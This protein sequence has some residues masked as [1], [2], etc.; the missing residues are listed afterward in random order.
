M[1]SGETKPHQNVFGIQI[2]SY[3]ASHF[4]CPRDTPICT[5]FPWGG[6]EVVL[7]FI[8]VFFEGVWHTT[9]SEG[10]LRTGPTLSLMDLKCAKALHTSQIFINAWTKNTTVTKPIFFSNSKSMSDHV[11]PRQAPRG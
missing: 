1:R 5:V 4:F 11:I 2:I 7:S 10:R 6:K 9:H 3:T 8:G